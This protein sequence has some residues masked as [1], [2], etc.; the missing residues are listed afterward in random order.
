MISHSRIFTFSCRAGCFNLPDSVP[1]RITPD[2]GIL[3]TGE[4]C[5]VSIEFSPVIPTH[6]IIELAREESKEREKEKE[7]D[8]EETKSGEGGASSRTSTLEKK[9]TCL[10]G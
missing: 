5:K 3:A 6:E 8:K 2:A 7:K 10:T 9:N 1:I 4:E